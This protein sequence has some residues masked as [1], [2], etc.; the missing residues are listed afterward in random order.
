MDRKGNIRMLKAFGYY[1]P[2]KDTF[3]YDPNDK[4]EKEKPSF[5]YEY[6]S[7]FY[8]IDESSDLVNDKWD[9]TLQSSLQPKVRAK[10]TS[11]VKGKIDYTNDRYEQVMG[12][13]DYK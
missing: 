7:Q 9:K 5:I 6:S 2:T 3:K 11:R 13:K 8:E 10:G 12:N 1:A 4:E